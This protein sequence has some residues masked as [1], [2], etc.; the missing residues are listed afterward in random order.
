MMQSEKYL[1]QVGNPRWADLLIKMVVNPNFLISS[2]LSCQKWQTQKE[3]E[4]QGH[5]YK[6]DATINKG[7]VRL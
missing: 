5:L 2:H 4:R 7:C 1:E 3:I 6:R